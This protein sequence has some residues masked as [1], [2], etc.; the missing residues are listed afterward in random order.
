KID[1]ALRGVL[2][3]VAQNIRQLKSDAAFFGQR[4]SAARIESEDVDDGQA[5]HARHL[6]AI[7]IEL[8]ERLYAPR[9]Q[10]AR[11]AVDHLPEVL[12]RNPE[13]LYRVVEPR[14][15]RVP[16]EAPFERVLQFHAPLLDRRPRGA[17]LVAQIVAV[18]HER[19]DG[20]HGLA[21]LGAQQDV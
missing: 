17:R 18:A 5:D 14:P 10:V 16:A 15:D 6:I 19:V 9:L 13:A 2:L 7:L 1:A 3:N 20:A 12:V 11:D 8:V 4:Q 21:L